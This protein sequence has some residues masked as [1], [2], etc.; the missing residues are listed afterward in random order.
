M[1][2]LLTFFSGVVLGGLVG[3]AL[4]LLFTPASGEQ[5]R[6]NIQ[7]RYIELRDEVQQAAES[8]RIELEE[9]LR[10]LRKPAKSG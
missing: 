7:S 9:Q 1:R 2:R 10:E 4:A 3:A 5:L 8:R 6:G